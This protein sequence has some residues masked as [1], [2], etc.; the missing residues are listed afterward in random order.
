MADQTQIRYK[1]LPGRG[2]R[3]R[4]I[5][6]AF[7][8][9]C[10][11][12]L[13]DDHLLAIDNHGFSEDYKRFYFADI[14]AVITR[15]TR[16]GATWNIVLALVIA[17]T[18][19]GVLFPKAEALRIFFWIVCL[20]FLAL[21]VINIL[22]G[23]TCICHII[24]AVQADELPSLNRL[25]VARK[26]IRLLRS[27]IEK[28]QGTLSAEELGETL[29]TGLIPASAPARPVQD[30]QQ[31]PR[32]YAG[33]AHLIAFALLL[34]DGIFTGVSLLH[35]APVMTLI[36]NVLLA[37]SFIFI[38]IALAK[39]HDTD[40]P[41]TVRGITWTSI[42]FVCVSTF[43]SYILMFTALMSNPQAFVTQWEMYQAMLALSPQDYP[44]I[45]AVY[46]VS[47]ACS[48]VLGVLGLFRVLKH[49]A[50]NTTTPLLQPR[51]GA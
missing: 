34:A 48:L 42:G 11:L 45:L 21:L 31:Q 37:L 43:L 12:Y 9:R 13:G 40:I 27:A 23:P 33:A 18:L 35:H 30:R 25:R 26:V 38:I 29:A 19:P 47:A 39:Q 44:L 49:R 16:R 5:L 17:S 6:R 10:S 50:A 51:E 1:R 32:H 20:F 15:Q 4:G 28:V 3:A 14:Q 36:A 7:L 22:R 41:G 24:T 46:G 8:T 2:P